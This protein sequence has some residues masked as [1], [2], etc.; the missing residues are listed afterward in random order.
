VVSTVLPIIVVLLSM[1]ALR[2]SCLQSL[3]AS[4]AEIARASLL[5]VVAHHRL[6]ELAAADKEVPR[7]HAEHDDD[8]NLLHST[9]RACAARSDFAGQYTLTNVSKTGVD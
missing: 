2:L 9:S 7:A 5:V 6:V 4:L 8:R 1:T 3:S